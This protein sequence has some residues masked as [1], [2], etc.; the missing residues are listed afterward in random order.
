MMLLPPACKHCEAERALFR[1]PFL[2][3]PPLFFPLLP[4]CL[5]AFTVVGGFVV[6]RNGV[7]KLAHQG[8]DRYMMQGPTPPLLVAY[9]V[10]SEGR[11]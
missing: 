10:P 8:Q 9:L 1:A 5:S 11:A 4:S 2:V 6:V 7:D 3:F